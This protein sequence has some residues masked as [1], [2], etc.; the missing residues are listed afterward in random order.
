MRL[1]ATADTDSLPVDD[2]KQLRQLVSNANFFAL[3]ETIAPQTA[4]PDRFQ[5][6]V[7]IEDGGR[8]HT[9]TTSESA[10]PPS[11]RPLTDFMSRHGR[12]Q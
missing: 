9:V 6:S 5:Y 8:V 2:A 12:R 11:L 4:H 1:T 3:P 10:L 7:T